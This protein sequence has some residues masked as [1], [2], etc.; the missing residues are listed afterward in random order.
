M[1]HCEI[2]QGCILRRRDAESAG[3]AIGVCMVT[4]VTCC[5]CVAPLMNSKAT[6]QITDFI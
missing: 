4:Y 2:G 1:Q 3:K 6:D 5:Q